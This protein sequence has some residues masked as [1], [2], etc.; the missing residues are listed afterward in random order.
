MCTCACTCLEQTADPV[1]VSTYI[2]VCDPGLLVISE[3]ID[4]EL[5][6]RFYFQ[7]VE[8][9]VIWDVK[10]KD[11]STTFA[12]TNNVNV[13]PHVK[14]HWKLPEQQETRAGTP[15]QSRW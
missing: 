8:C 12:F 3:N 5:P 13:I 9:V 1:L 4:F 7:D 11:Q 10:E 6:A 2:D 15:R 14:N